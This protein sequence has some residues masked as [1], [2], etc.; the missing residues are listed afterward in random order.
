[1]AIDYNKLREILERKA[2]KAIGYLD[3]LK[4]FVP[5]FRDVLDSVL[6]I[7]ETLKDLMFL[8]TECSD[9]KKEKQEVDQKPQQKLKD[10]QAE[11]EAI[12]GMPYQSLDGSTP[13]GK[14]AVLF[15]SDGCEP[16]QHMKPVF[17]EVTAELE[18]PVELV[19][20]DTA[21]GE[22]HARN[23]EVN[24]WPRI[25]LVDNGQI[26]FQIPGYNLSAPVEENKADLKN[27]MRHYLNL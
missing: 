3:E 2:N 1:M 17:N 8:D 7:S 10:R 5:E 13:Q 23:Y 4:C 11:L 27:T 6:Y 9:C 16:C 15:Y 26:V 19:S 20:V 24:G 21:I 22:G 25:F 18:L 12:I 14:L